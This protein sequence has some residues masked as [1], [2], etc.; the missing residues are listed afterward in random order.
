M[1]TEN[2]ENINDSDMRAKNNIH[3]ITGTQKRR[4]PEEFQT[5]IHALF[6]DEIK[7]VNNK[8]PSINLWYLR[9]RKKSK[10]NFYG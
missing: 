6:H 10:H 9:I 7:K 3:E 2:C 1:E 4:S 5:Y 8:N